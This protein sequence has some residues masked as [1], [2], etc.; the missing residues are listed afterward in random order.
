ML[1][2]NLIEIIPHDAVH[3]AAMYTARKRAHELRKRA[4]LKQGVISQQICRDGQMHQADLSGL[5]DRSAQEPGIPLLRRQRQY[6]HGWYG[7]ERTCID[8][9]HVG[10]ADIQLSQQLRQHSKVGGGRQSFSQ[11]IVRI[12]HERPVQYRAR[13]DGDTVRRSDV[14]E[15]EVVLCRFDM[16][17]RHSGIADQNKGATQKRVGHQVNLTVGNPRKMPV[18]GVTMVW[19]ANGMSQLV[20]DSRRDTDRKGAD[21]GY[22]RGTQALGD[23]DSHAMYGP[24]R[25]NTQVTDAKKKGA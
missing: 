11:S 9:R 23:V 8:N 21:A 17:G 10:I 14:Y 13:H 6:K 22:S 18:T 2:A 5:Y 19:D 4:G 16:R 24:W 12:E 20:R 25:A 1:V 15:D 7:K 3:V